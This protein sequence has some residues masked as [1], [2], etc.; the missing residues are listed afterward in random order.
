M[1][2]ATIFLGPIAF[3][4]ALWRYRGDFVYV[5]RRDGRCGN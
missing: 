1:M 3:A 2:H 5:D 4:V